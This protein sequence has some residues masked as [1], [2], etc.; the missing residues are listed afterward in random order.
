MD[1]RIVGSF[2]RVAC[3]LTI[4]GLKESCSS[5]MRVFDDMI[6]SCESIFT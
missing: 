4:M 1:Y 3:G 6:R 5:F 2:S